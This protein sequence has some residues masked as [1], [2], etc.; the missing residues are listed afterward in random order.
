MPTLN[1][2]E[3]TN[4]NWTKTVFSCTVFALK[5]KKGA[6]SCTQQANL[7]DEDTIEQIKGFLINCYN[8]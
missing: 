7:H 4:P 8:F 5:I 3:F 1:A 6:I 2:R